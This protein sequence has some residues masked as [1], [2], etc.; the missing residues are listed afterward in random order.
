[1]SP[2]GVIF[3]LIVATASAGQARNCP[4]YWINFRGNDLY[5]VSRVLSWESCGKLNNISIITTYN[6]D[7]G[8]SCRADPQCTH[9]T[10]DHL[11]HPFTPQRCWLKHSS[12]PWNDDYVNPEA[13]CG[14][15]SG[16]VYCFSQQFQQNM[17]GIEI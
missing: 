8:E 1:M 16:D 12:A 10:W 11:S 7:L 6:S 14:S 13:E 17:T 5:Q 15:I 4:E 9:W 3:L 2:T